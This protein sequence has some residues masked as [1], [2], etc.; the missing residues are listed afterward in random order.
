MGWSKMPL[1]VVLLCTDVHWGLC[2]WTNRAPQGF[3]WQMSLKETN[4]GRSANTAP[5]LT[6]FL[7]L[8]PFPYLVTL[9]KDSVEILSVCFEIV[10]LQVLALFLRRKLLWQ[11]SHRYEWA[12]RGQTFTKMGYW[13]PV[14]KTHHRDGPYVVYEHLEEKES[15]YW[16]HAPLEPYAVNPLSSFTQ[17]TNS[18]TSWICT[19]L[20]DV[21]SSS[22]LSPGTE[23]WADSLEATPMKVNVI[24]HL[25]Y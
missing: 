9:F 4:S 18:S 13:N 5:T 7:S 10:C 6:E 20:E 12:R 3:S 25:K 2:F 11:E 15:Y 22:C 24:L 14:S 23:L 19:D 16:S 21:R 8:S 1:A 17:S